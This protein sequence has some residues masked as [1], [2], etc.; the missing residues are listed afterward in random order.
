MDLETARTRAGYAPLY[1]HI[2]A[3]KVGSTTI[4]AFLR[5]HQAALAR[6]GIIYPEIGRVALGHHHQLA[7]GFRDGDPKK[8]TPLW[9]RLR[10]LRQATPPDQRVV[11]SS[12]MFQALKPEAVE[13]IRRIAG[14]GPVRILFYIRDLA[15]TVVATYSQRTKAGTNLRDFD[16][17]FA[18]Y[19]ERIAERRAEVARL[20]SQVFGADNVRVR[21]LHP[22]TLVGGDLMED[23][24]HTLGSSLAALGVEQVGRK[25]VSPG[26]KM[27][28]TI[29]AAWQALRP[30]AADD[31]RLSPRFVQA[32]DAAASDPRVAG[33]RGE[34]LTLEQ[35]RICDELT[36]KLAAEIGS[37]QSDSR[38][39]IPPGPETRE[40]GFL[41]TFEQVSKLEAVHIM[42]EI[43]A[44]L[45]ARAGKLQAAETEDEDG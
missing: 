12:E 21:A 41:P 8:S 4:Q 24:L 2:G 32:I 36:A 1:I 37:L 13:R 27:N 14:D 35:R 16:Q 20:W 29:R 3:K 33:E 39:I 17:F 45:L 38:I 43:S 5:D 22:E 26:W 34:Y 18:R 30:H 25:N 7:L 15:G 23:L 19:V 31:A 10:Q 44:V 42:A 6:A 28:E 11:V 40:R 9:H